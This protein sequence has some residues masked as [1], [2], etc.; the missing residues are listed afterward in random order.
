[1]V[2]VCDLEGKSMMIGIPV[3]NSHM[4]NVTL[5]ALA[6]A[7]PEFFLCFFSTF[8]DIEAIPQ[9]IGPIVLIGKGSF[10]LLVVTGVSI[11]SISEIK[12]V[13]DYKVFVVT[14]CFATFS[15]LWIFLI[16]VVFSPA[17]IEFWE[18][19]MTL[20]FF[21]TLLTLIWTTEKCGDN[22]WSESEE[23]E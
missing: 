10:N 9:D 6:S 17:Y 2:E 1:M 20:L 18:A 22:Q 21:P 23:L 15:Y 4:A 5:L 12:K 8:A 7:A 16:L 14:A 11:L 19:L 3:W 13:K